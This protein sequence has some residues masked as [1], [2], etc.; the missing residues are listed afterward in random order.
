MNSEQ[1]KTN[2][3]SWKITYLFT[4]RHKSLL[5]SKYLESLSVAAVSSNRA[6]N[7]TAVSIN[8]AAEEAWI[9]SLDTVCMFCCALGN[10]Q[11]QTL[12]PNVAFGP[13]DIYFI[14]GC[15]S[16]TF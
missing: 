3:I 13:L 12:A 14:Q 6:A 11:I 15:D 2:T 9:L 8:R 10:T 7:Q 16:L 5:N 1:H 4:P